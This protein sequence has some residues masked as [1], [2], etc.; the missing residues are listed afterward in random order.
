[1]AAIKRVLI[2]VTFNKEETLGFAL[3]RNE[4]GEIYVSSIDENS[5]SNNLDIKLY[6]QFIGYI[7]NGFESFRNTPY[8]IEEWNDLKYTI[9]T[10]SRPVTIRF[11]RLI[12]P[13]IKAHIPD[14]RV[15][16]K[17]VYHLIADDIDN[18]ESKLLAALQHCCSYHKYQLQTS[19]YYPPSKRTES[20]FKV[21][22]STDELSHYYIFHHDRH[23]Y[24][25]LHR[26]CSNN[27]LECVGLLLD[28]GHPINLT[29]RFGVRAIDIALESENMDIV[30]HLLDRNA[31][32]DRDLA[33]GSRF[34]KDEVY[35]RTSKTEFDSFINTYI[36]SATTKE[37]IQ[38][39]FYPDN[40]G[41]QFPSRWYP[42]TPIIGWQRARELVHKYYFDDIFFILH[43][44]VAIVCN[45]ENQITSS[46]NM[47][48]ILQIMDNNSTYSLM[49]ILTSYLKS[50]LQSNLGK[51]EVISFV[52]DGINNVTGKTAPNCS[53]QIIVGNWYDTDTNSL[54][55]NAESFRVLKN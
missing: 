39:V 3:K 43:F 47:K 31:F 22:K 25:A 12:Y 44:H 21:D 13:N 41:G 37:S 15:M 4:N 32:I 42:S 40:Y 49:T 7:N 54:I 33:I 45:S 18:K 48:D 23:E 2:D 11:F 34:I 26:A 30:R 8:T 36:E 38:S 50:Y 27:N 14:K 28:A 6:D 10:F 5:Q 20:L 35:N 52:N 16:A 24:N 55:L 9:K 19:A 46:N 17:Y 53:K 51:Y 29:N 1:M